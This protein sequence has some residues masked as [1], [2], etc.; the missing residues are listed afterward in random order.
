[1]AGRILTE[2][3]IVGGG[4]VGCSTA[5]HFA[6]R[7]VPCVLLE[8]ERCGAHASG[9][10][11]GGI[12]IQGRALA[13]LPLAER[14][15]R[16]WGRLDR[17]V[18]ADGEFRATG[19]LRI[20][21]DEAE[22]ATLERWALEAARHGVRCELLPAEVLRSRFPWLGEGFAAASYCPDDGQANPRIVTPLF[23]RTAR[24]EG[25]TILE[26]RAVVSIERTSRG[27]LLRAEPELEVEARVLVNA[28][29]AWGTAIAAM[30]GEHL[31]SEP[32]A[33]NMLVSEPL[34]FKIEPN[35][36][37]AG[38][39]IYL[40]QVP[41][42]SVVFGGGRGSVDLE[43]RRCR[44]LF[45]TSLSTIEEACRVVPELARASI[46]R[47]WAGIEGRT[48][49]DLPV[50]GPSTVV[51]GLFHAFGFSGHGF[52]L[53]PAVGIVLVELVLDGHSATSLEGL[54]PSRSTSV[55]AIPAT[56]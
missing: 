41:S 56:T 27:F 1:M 42:G 34:P 18:G 22:A 49:D 29:G 20:A 54:S 24:E 46:I 16:R 35:I 11:Y 47:T 33:P 43:R 5:L 10:N 13:E 3:A 15:R 30:L 21:R 40:R 4:L 39:G 12:R 36:G 55:P 23:A 37:M 38:P 14:A 50:I 8:A 53:A 6:R 31:P 45:A 17:I 51:P 48:P 44:P 25:A 52:M 26:G 28:A 19:H 9:V 2:V 32:I 7:R